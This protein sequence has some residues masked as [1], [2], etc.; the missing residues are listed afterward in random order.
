M[1]E[2]LT[3]PSWRPRVGQLD[4]RIT[5]MRMRSG[6]GSGLSECGGSTSSA[7]TTGPTS[8]SEQAGASLPSTLPLPLPPPPQTL[9]RLWGTSHF[10]W[11]LRHFCNKSDDYFVIS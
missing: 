3:M 11:S 2:D 4:A 10:P 1:A 9:C 8:T 5:W 7:Q 6:S